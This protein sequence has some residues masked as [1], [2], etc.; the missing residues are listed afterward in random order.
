L[1]RVLI[2]RHHHRAIFSIAQHHHRAALSIAQHHHRAALSIAQ[3]HHCAALSITRYHHRAVISS[4]RH[5]H[6]AALS[7]AQY[8]H[9][10]VSFIARHRYR[11]AL[12]IA[13]Y[14]HRTVLSSRGIIHRATSSSHGILQHHLRYGIARNHPLHGIARNHHRAASSFVWSVY[15]VC[16]ALDFLSRYPYRT[17]ALYSHALRQKS[18]KGEKPHLRSYLFVCASPLVQRLLVLLALTGLRAGSY[19]LLVC[20]AQRIALCALCVAKDETSVD[21]MRRRLCCNFLRKSRL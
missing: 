6:R 4:A 7:I 2:A 1:R 19:W 14:Y 9:R 16:N 21:F 12:S 18:R 11:A 8:H 15:F 5:R 17:R 3:H 20:K 13:R 10:A